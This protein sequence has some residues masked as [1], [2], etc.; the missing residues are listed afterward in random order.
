MNPIRAARF[1]DIPA[2]V[3]MLVEQQAKSI[4]AGRVSVDREHTRRLLAAMT[5]RHG[6]TNDGGTCVFVVTDGISEVCGFVVGV[7]GRVYHIGVEL[8]AQDAF[9]VVTPK[10][11]KNAVIQL[12][13]A[14]VGWAET[15]PKVRE[16][17]L[18]HSAAIAGSERIATLYRRKGFT[19]FGHS[20]RREIVAVEN[21]RE[22]A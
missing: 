17:Q 13:D 22:A 21:A 20:Y 18:S 2:L 15:S 9:L 19:P 12:I 16:I 6:H 8:M 7:L 3:D 1:V 4:Y 11:P 5:Q 14:Y 10:A